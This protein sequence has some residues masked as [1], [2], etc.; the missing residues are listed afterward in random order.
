M[1]NEDSENENKLRARV[2]IFLQDQWQGWEKKWG[3]ES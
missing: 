3:S 1:V 2:Y